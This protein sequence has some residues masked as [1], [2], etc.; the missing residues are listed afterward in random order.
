[1]AKAGIPIKPFWQTDMAMGNQKNT[2]HYVNW[3]LKRKGSYP[4]GT[5]IA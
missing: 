2:H 3:V 4:A 5:F 1:M